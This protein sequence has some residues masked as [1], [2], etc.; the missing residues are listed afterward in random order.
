MNNVEEKLVKLLGERLIEQLERK[1]KLKLTIPMRSV[2]NVKFDKEKGILTMGDKTRERSFLDLKGVRVFTQTICVAKILVEGLREKILSTKRD[3][4]YSHTF[5]VPGMKR[6][7]FDSQTESDSILEDI[8]VLTGMFMEDMGV[9]AEP[10]GMMVGYVK[11]RSGKHIIN[12]SKQGDGAWTIPSLMG[13]VRL[14]SSSARFILLVEKG[15]VFQKLNST[16][17][18]EKWRCIL[19]TARG[20]PDRATRRMVKRLH[21]EFNLPVYCLVD[22]DPYGWQI[23]TVYKHGSANLAHESERLACPAIKFLGVSLSD[24]EKYKIPSKY[25]DPATPH[26][27][28]RARDLLKLEWLSE[29]HEE[30]RLFLKKRRKAEIETLSRRGLKFLLDKYLPEKLSSF[31]VKEP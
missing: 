10:K 22:S 21:E 1:E 14:I 20:Q 23:Y 3:I 15:T 31:G 9:V 11:L 19:I 8:E 30:L 18:W 24:I 27:L 5:P 6:D 7:I 12:C 25:L 26:D 29:F 4:Y 13:N 16:G 17:W 28:K 2:V